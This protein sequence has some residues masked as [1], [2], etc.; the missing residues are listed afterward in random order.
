MQ[1]D[2]GDDDLQDNLYR[3][4]HAKVW[5]VEVRRTGYGDILGTNGD[6]VTV[7]DTVEN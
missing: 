3:H 6:N 1:Y 4:A 7:K 2:F 5:G